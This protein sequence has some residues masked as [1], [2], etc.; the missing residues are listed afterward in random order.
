MDVLRLSSSCTCL[1]TF[2]LNIETTND[3]IIIIAWNACAYSELK[4][5]LQLVETD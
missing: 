1:M 2:D 4:Y 3:N 5:D